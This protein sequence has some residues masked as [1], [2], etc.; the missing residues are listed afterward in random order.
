MGYEG[1]KKNVV[2]TP[3]LEVFQET[4][5]ILTRRKHT[6]YDSHT[7]NQFSRRWSQS[8]TSTAV[9]QTCCVASLE[10]TPLKKKHIWTSGR[11]FF[12]YV[13]SYQKHTHPCEISEY[14]TQHGQLLKTKPI[15][16]MIFY[17]KSP[18]FRCLFSVWSLS[19]ASKEL[20]GHT[21]WR[22]PRWSPLL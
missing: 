20:A 11:F 5:C 18:F 4:C 15:Q 16:T 13:P 1:L 19:L 17:I 6:E 21:G 2:C 8:E 22:Y 7:L 3:Q 10:A 14:N 12:F 9:E